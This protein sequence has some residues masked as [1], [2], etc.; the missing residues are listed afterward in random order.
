MR[1]TKLKIKPTG[2]MLTPGF[3]ASLIGSFGIL[4]LMVIGFIFP[5]VVPL[6]F[7]VIPGFFAICLATGLLAGIFAGDK[8]GWKSHQ[9]V[10]APKFSQHLFTYWQ[11]ERHPWPFQCFEG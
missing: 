10:S 3:T 6:A 5:L 1:Y 11:L 2:L 8:S 4:I 7:V 9:T